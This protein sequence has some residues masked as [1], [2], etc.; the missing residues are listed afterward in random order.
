MG[1][2]VARWRYQKPGF[3]DKISGGWFVFDKAKGQ[4]PIAGPFSPKSEAIRARDALRVQRK[5]SGMADEKK[6][7]EDPTAG[8]S[9]ESTSTAKTTEHKTETTREGEGSDD[10][11][12]R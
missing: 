10:S 3:R 5:E 12:K 8:K 6:S 2:M 4:R 9:S 1:L 7:T 11:S